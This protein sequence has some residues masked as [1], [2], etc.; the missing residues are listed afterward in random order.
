MWRLEELDCSGFM[1]FC[2]GLFGGFVLGK[3]V[4]GPFSELVWNKLGLVRSNFNF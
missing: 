4:Y 2:C 1:G 3:L